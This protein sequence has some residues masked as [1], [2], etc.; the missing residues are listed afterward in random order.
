MQQLI[1]RSVQL[2]RNVT[3][4][5][6][7]VLLSLLADKSSQGLLEPART[8]DLLSEAVTISSYNSAALRD[9]LH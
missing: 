3:L 6:C 2:S 5:D 9:Y 7:S 8:L 4:S 1:C